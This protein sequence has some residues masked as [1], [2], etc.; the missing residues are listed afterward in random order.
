[1]VN[2][3]DFGLSPGVNRGVLRAHVEGIVTSTS[4]MVRQPA[5]A[6]AVR[7]ANEYPRLSL[8]LHVDLA[9]WRYGDGEWRMLYARVDLSDVRAVAAE[10]EGQLAAFGALVGRLPTHLDSH[11]H[12]HR[13][14]PVRA[15]LADTARVLGIPLRHQPPVHYCGAFYGQGRDGAPM[16]DAITPGALATVIRRLPAGTT[17]LCCHP[18]ESADPGWA[19]GAERRVEL[20]SLCHPA[21]RRAVNEAGVC[22]ASFADG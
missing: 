1:M 9:E 4:L 20:A 16:P 5:A 12:V 8:G 19:Y 15:I 3:D 11:Q 22:L 6:E 17:E 10:V 14:E 2:A 7:A 21:V 13:D 18:A